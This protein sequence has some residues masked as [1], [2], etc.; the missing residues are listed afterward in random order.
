MYGGVDAEVTLECKNELAGVI[1][2]CFGHGV[3]LIP[4]GE[5][6]FTLLYFYYCTSSL[7]RFRICIYT[8]FLEMFSEFAT[9]MTAS[10]KLKIPLL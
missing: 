3:W 7:F 4:Q 9:F 10:F 8:V 5:D 6:R 2:D 1:I